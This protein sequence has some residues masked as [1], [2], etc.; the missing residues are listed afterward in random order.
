MLRNGNT[1]DGNRTGPRAAE[2]KGMHVLVR[3]KVID[4]YIA[5]LQYR[6]SEWK[7]STQV[8]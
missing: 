6:N 8:P 5:K 1:Y 4:E 7:T 3:G 2:K